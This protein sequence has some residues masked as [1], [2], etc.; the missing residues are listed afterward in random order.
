M[1]EPSFHSIEN[2]TINSQPDIAEHEID[3]KQIKSNVNSTSINDASITETVGIL[4]ESKVW[5]LDQ[6]DNDAAL[7]LWG[8][9]LNSEQLT[10]FNFFIQ[11][12]WWY[13][14]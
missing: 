1:L 4:S 14:R 12:G 10:T 5:N 8:M 2:D 9:W 7:L 11:N 13:F 3:N 6:L